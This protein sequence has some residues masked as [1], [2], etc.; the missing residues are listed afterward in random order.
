MDLHNQ[1][2]V[3]YPSSEEIEPEQARFLYEQ[4]CAILIIE[5]LPLGSEFGIDLVA[6]RVGEKFKGVKLIPPG[7]HFIYA[8]ATD[9][10]K[11]HCGPRCGFFH[12]FQQREL[13]IKKWSSSEEDFD[14]NYRPSD[15][16]EARYR[17]NIRDLDPYLGAYSFSNYH[18][19]LG[20]TNNLKPTVV[21]SLTP[22]CGRIRSVPYLTRDSDI[23]GY[24]K[25]KRIVRATLKSDPTTTE[26][27]LLPDLKPEQSTVIH[28]TPV[29][30]S[31]IDSTY[32]ISPEMITSYNL[33]SSTKFD[34]SF[35]GEDGRRRF[36]GEFQFAFIVFL[37]CH[38]YECFE[39]WKTL[40]S[41]VCMADSN[42]SKYPTFYE[43]FIVSLKNQV[44]HIPG[45]LFD[46]IVDSNNAVRSLLD[47]FFQNLENCPSEIGGLRQCAK[48]LRKHL[49]DKFNWSFDLEVDDEQPVVVEL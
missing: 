36:L 10:E 27:T 26:E 8:S 48:D 41:L 17:Q 39:Q 46:D 1:L 15:E 28:F 19:Y 35:R 43:E 40:L 9:K 23:S 47:T 32:P 37:L 2:N 45:D 29:P 11:Q 5:G 16:H 3:E 22:D 14:D 13:I 42:L 7:V 6:Y 12:N 18:K 4:H 49:E 38:V 21:R 44:D 34:H 33:D 25:S 31:H 24:D 30:Q 20:L